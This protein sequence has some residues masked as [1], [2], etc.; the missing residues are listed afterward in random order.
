MGISPTTT[1]AYEQEVLWFGEPYPLRVSRNDVLRFPE[2]MNLCT[3]GGPIKD[4][5][6]SRHKTTGQIEGCM[7][8]ALGLD[9]DHYCS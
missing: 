2:V 6:R 1:T 4:P 3:K 9:F 7:M 8:V 5:F